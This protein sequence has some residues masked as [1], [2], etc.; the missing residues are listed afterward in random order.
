MQVFFKTIASYKFFYA[1]G[2]VPAQAWP[3]RSALKSDGA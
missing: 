3:L 2:A 1:A